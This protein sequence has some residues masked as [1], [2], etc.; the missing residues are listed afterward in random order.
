MIGYP[1]RGSVQS[2]EDSTLAPTVCVL[3]FRK[4]YVLLEVRGIFP[5]LWW[6]IGAILPRQAG[7][8]YRQR[9]VGEP[10]SGSISAEAR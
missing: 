7:R 5:P 10:A 6:L 2:A 4:G 8:A 1:H 9:H 3:T